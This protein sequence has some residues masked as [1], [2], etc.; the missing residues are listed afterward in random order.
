MQAVAIFVAGFVLAFAVFS[1]GI[2]LLYA[3]AVIRKLL[4]GRGTFRGR[5]RQF[6]RE[7]WDFPHGH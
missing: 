4:F 5:W 1:Y 3:V 2:T 6:K 7:V